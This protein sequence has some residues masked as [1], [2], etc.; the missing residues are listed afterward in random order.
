M[1]DV[2]VSIHVAAGAPFH[3]F[4]QHADRNVGTG[5]ELGDGVETGQP[6]ALLQPADCIAA[7]L[8]EIAEPFLTE[9]GPA[10]RAPEVDA[11]PLRQRR[12]RA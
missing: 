5:G 6:L 9:I 12:V 10:A 3:P 11:E 8:D 2:E 4:E 7:Q 1:L